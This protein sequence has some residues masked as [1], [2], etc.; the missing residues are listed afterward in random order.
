[1]MRSS[2]SGSYITDVASV[3]IDAIK[4]LVYHLN[5]PYDIANFFL[6]F[7]ELEIQLED[8]HFLRA[9]S[10][11]FGL[12]IAVTVSEFIDNSR[13]YDSSTKNK[14]LHVTNKCDENSFYRSLYL[15]DDMTSVA[16]RAQM[17]YVL[18]RASLI[19]CESLVLISIEKGATD[20]VN[21]IDYAISGDNPNIVIILLDQA[22]LSR[23][24]IPMYVYAIV[25]FY[26]L[27]NNY[28][29]LLNY[30]LLVLGYILPREDMDYINEDV[31]NMIEVMKN[32]NDVIDNVLSY[33]V[34]SDNNT[35][36]IIKAL[37]DKNVLTTGD[38]NRIID[39]SF[40]YNN[41]NILEYLVEHNLTTAND[42]LLIAV[43]YDNIN[44]IERMIKLGADNIMTA[45]NRAR[46]RNYKDAEI[47]LR[48]HLH[49]I[50]DQQ[51]M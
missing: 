46:S 44:I 34:K 40:I 30:V 29:D 6:S 23:A 41:L 32:N 22:L 10:I 17:N 24:H 12:P 31:F 15:T 47:L 50:Y 14:L 2:L 7:D 38:I 4:E 3:T 49:D 20:F 21:A 51:Y 33:L 18:S 28:D 13:L 27:A 26:S 36:S 25:L 39:Q 8:R 5:N 35:S 11:K 43:D 19:N 48:N 45:I 37:I 9:L 16:K 1:M 42:L